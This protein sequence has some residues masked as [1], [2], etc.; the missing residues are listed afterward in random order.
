[1]IGIYWTNRKIGISWDIYSIFIYSIYIRP[2]RHHVQ[3]LDVGGI[4]NS[5]GRL[6]GRNSSGFM[7]AN[8]FKDSHLAC[9]SV[10]IP[11]TRESQTFW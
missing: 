3:P 5:W 7:F 10:R 1:M 9:N 4:S 2:Q 8:Q 6:L 11:G